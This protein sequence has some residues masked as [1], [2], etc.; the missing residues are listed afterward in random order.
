MARQLRKL[1][2]LM[3]GLKWWIVAVWAILLA[4]LAVVMFQVGPTTSSSI[5]IPGTQ[6]QKTL[7]QFHELFPDTGAQSSKVVVAAEEGK[8]SAD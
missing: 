4:V 3:F 8:T 6:A 1:G 7:D 5:S 2:E